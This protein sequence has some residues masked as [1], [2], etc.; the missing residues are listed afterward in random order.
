M[1]D[2]F[3]F[4]MATDL[5]LAEDVTRTVVMDHKV[6][7]AAGTSN[8]FKQTIE[9]ARASPGW[10]GMMAALMQIAE[11]VNSDLASIW[12]GLERGRLDWLA[13]CRGAHAVKTTL[14]DALERDND[15]T[16]RDVVDAKMIW[17]YSLATCIPNLQDVAQVWQETVGIKDNMR[18]LVGYNAK[19][20]DCRKEVWA[21]VDLGVQAAAER[22]G[23]SID[24]AWNL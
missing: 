8:S 15:A 20:W 12:M 1:R 17:I 5:S 24:E 14:K 2:G 18:P 6:A 16:E 21:P 13:A 19:L 9:S 3:Y 11:S 7:V 10:D 4:G 22:G 23:S